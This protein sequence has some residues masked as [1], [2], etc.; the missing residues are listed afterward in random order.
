MKI[1]RI[2]AMWCPSCIMVNKYWNDVKNE[3]S[4]IEFID[5]DLD[6][7]EEESL[8]LNPGKI[9]PVFI[10]FKDDIEVRRIIGEKKKD[11]MYNL[12]KDVF[13]L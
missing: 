11:E 13:S 9:L 3:F 1:V 7:D 6:L 5:L 2:G 12:I 4:N 10:F 8:L